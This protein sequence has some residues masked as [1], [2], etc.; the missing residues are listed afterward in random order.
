MA[1][2][3]AEVIRWEP[4]YGQHHGPKICGGNPHTGEASVA[5]AGVVVLRGF[6]TGPSDQRISA[7]GPAAS[8]RIDVWSCGHHS[9]KSVERCQLAETDPRLL[10][11][12]R[13]VMRRHQARPPQLLIFVCCVA[14]PPLPPAKLL[15]PESSGRVE[16]HG[17]LLKNNCIFLKQDHSRPAL[18]QCRSKL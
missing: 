15:T 18:G 14:R 3:F 12:K 8:S 7:V 10:R 11:C 5:V 2:K 9:D 17:F 4:A 1:P 16:S 13:M 6:E